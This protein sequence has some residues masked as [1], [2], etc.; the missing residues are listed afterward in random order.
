MALSCGGAGNTAN[1]QIATPSGPSTIVNA[2]AAGSNVEELGVIV[3]VPY[4]A[5]DVVWKQSPD[6][7]KVL[8]V[9]R[10][11][12]A[13]SNKLVAEAQLLGPPSAVAI[14][15]ESW[16]PEELVAQS[17]VSGDSALKGTAYP[18]NQ[19]FLE[20]FTK[21]RITRVNETD[22]FVLELTSDK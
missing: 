12:D 1:S 11:S 9:L 20:P 16:F 2:N 19:F 5:E 8:A 14:P 15:S 21:G 6:K 17:D 22:Y 18:A 13:D 3:N 4:A 10:F 7:K